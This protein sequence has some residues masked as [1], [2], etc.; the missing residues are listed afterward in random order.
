MKETKGNGEFYEIFGTKFRRVTSILARLK[1]FGLE[2]WQATCAVDF[3]MSELVVPLHKGWMTIE[4]LRETD[5]ERVRRSA[6]DESR[7]RML[8]AQNKGRDVHK[9]IHDYY[10][11]GQDPAVLERIVKTDPDIAL[12]IGAFRKWERDYHVD[13]AASERQVLSV[14]RRYAGTLDLEAGI[15][16][17]NEDYGE[18]ENSRHYVIDFKTGNPDPVSVLQVAAYVVAVEEMD[19]CRIDGAGIVYLNR[20]TGIPRW[21]G[22]SRN[23]LLLPFLLFEK[24]KSFV[25]MEYDWRKKEPD[26]EGPPDTPMPPPAAPP[27]GTPPGGSSSIF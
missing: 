5:L 12:P 7:K 10:A 24:I 14:S 19:H 2:E 8:T 13:M 26:E 17:P 1:R 4:Q 23:E 18:K 21:K 9:A 20:E 11:A 3:M 16:L 27:A 25:D 6:M 15:V 22:Y